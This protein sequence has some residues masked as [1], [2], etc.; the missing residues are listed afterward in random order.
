MA[1]P[2][3]ERFRLP[4]GS[5]QECLQEPSDPKKDPCKIQVRESET[6]LNFVLERNQGTYQLAPADASLVVKAFPSY[7]P[8][9]REIAEYLNVRGVFFKVLGDEKNPNEI[10]KQ[11][12]FKHLLGEGQTVEAAIE[13]WV[14]VI[15][16]FISHGQMEPKG[17]KSKDF[18]EEAVKVATFFSIDP[19]LRSLAV[20]IL[21]G[22]KGNEKLSAVSRQRVEFLLVVLSVQ[23]AMLTKFKPAM[24]KSQAISDELRSRSSGLIQFLFNNHVLADKGFN[25]KL[26]ATW[27]LDSAKVFHDILSK[28]DPHYN[29]SKNYFAYIAS[30]MKDLKGIDLPS[31]YQKEFRIRANFIQSEYEKMGH[32][33]MFAILAGQDPEQSLREYLTI[34]YGSAPARAMVLETF[35][36][37]MKVK[38]GKTQPL[39]EFDMVKISEEVK[40]H[41]DALPIAMKVQAN[42]ALLSVLQELFEKSGKMEIYW[43]KK[44]QETDNFNSS[45]PLIGANKSALE[46]LI[47]WSRGQAKDVASF[48]PDQKIPHVS[49]RKWTLITELGIGAAGTATALGLLAVDES[50]PR[51][52]GQGAATIAAGAGF[53]AALGNTLSYAFDVD[54]AD[55]VFDVGGSLVGGLAAGLTYGFLVPKPGPGG[56]QPPP[57]PDPGRRFPVDPYGP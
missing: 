45:F 52:W 46:S 14:N 24:D 25:D 53:G 29:A 6:Q 48:D 40:K 39:F 21:E 30:V 43:D 7:K 2:V 28:V 44:T 17:A 3:Y 27:I 34:K 26:M 31:S 47:L 55:W 11:F 1:D 33:A 36:K 23:E 51:Y 54:E 5:V 37:H 9:A 4:G 38:P 22:L 18:Q 10:I 8:P 15:A 50:E 35:F 41:H 19:T 57:Q 42:T 56:T 20:K 12:K 16:S 32:E 13:S 49:L